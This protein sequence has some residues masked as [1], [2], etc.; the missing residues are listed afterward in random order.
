MNSLDTQLILVK[1]SSESPSSESLNNSMDMEFNE[2]K[3]LIDTKRE[4]REGIYFLI[5]VD[6]D[7]E[8]ESSNN[9]SFFGK[10]IWGKDEL[11]DSSTFEKKFNSLKKQNKK[12]S[13]KFAVTN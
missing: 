2:L 1:S 8:K 10:K 3:M 4:Q 13:S 7:N 9:N 5:F 6:F 12:V 11:D